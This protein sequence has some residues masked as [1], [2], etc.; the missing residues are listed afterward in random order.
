M[1]EG[2]HNLFLLGFF[3]LTYHLHIF[4]LFIN[5]VGEHFFLFTLCA[6]V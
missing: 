6:L 2:V 5:S 4:I 1:M 3:W